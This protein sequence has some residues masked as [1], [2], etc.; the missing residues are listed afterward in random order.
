ML[1]AILTLAL[2]ADSSLPMCTNDLEPI[3]QPSPSY[4][5]PAQSKRYG[6]GTTSYM[7]LFVEGSI[8]VEIHISTDGNVSDVVTLESSHSLVGTQRQN[9]NHSDFGDYLHINLKPTI[10]KWSFNPPDN[11]CRFVQ[12][13]TWELDREDA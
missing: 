1:F 10:F 4:P 3:S 7:H 5:T 6:L 13:F 2:G 8:L 12:R 9:Y 11:A